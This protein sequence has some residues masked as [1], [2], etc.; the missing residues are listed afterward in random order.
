M[1]RHDEIL[2]TAERLIR[3]EGFN[4]VSYRDI[5]A[6]VGIKSAS[7][8]YHFPAKEDLGVAVV[9]RYHEKFHA[10]LMAEAKDLPGPKD[11]LAAFID[12]HRRALHDDELLCLCAV[13]GAEAGGLPPS[14]VTAVKAFFTANI[15]WLSDVY[16]AMN[17]NG[18]ARR[19]KASAAA[20]EGALMTAMVNQDKDVFEATADWIMT[21]GA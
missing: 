14:V 10:A 16:S 1:T 3:R 5:A 20:L 19:A 21:P 6:K 13:L 2:E 11:K 12:L 15:D 7:L 9:S 4:A 18:P 8:H 17:V